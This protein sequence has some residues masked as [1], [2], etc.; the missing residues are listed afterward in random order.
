M[1]LSHS[2]RLKKAWITRRKNGNAEPINKKDIPPKRELTRL[3][4][5]EKRS[6][7]FIADM[8]KVSTTPVIRWL[9]EYDIELRDDS[10][11]AKIIRNGFKENDKHPNW[12]GDSVGYNA[13][14]VWVKKRKPRPKYC[15][16]CNK[17]KAIDLSNKGIYNRNLNNWEWLC[18]KCHM[19]L[20]AGLK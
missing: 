12:K 17:R 10:E 6:T 11:Q 1:K 4:L 13:L 8:F 14:H 16:H 18:R 2:E 3:Y 5:K 7:Y 9:R 19:T 20:T 15:E